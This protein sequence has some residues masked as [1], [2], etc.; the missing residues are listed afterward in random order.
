MK[1]N[2][3]KRILVPLAAGVLATLL[4]AGCTQPAT[5]TTTDADGNTVTI[6]WVDYPA[7]AG[8]PASDVL[9]LPM[10]EEVE[11]RAN[12]LISEVKDALEA[13]Y[14]ITEWTTS[15]E[16]GWF[17]EEG[18]GYGGTSLLTTYNSASHGA[19]I[20]IPVEQWDDV[21]DTVRTITQKYEISE[22][23]N[24][25]YIE[26]YPEWM[27]F[28]GFYRGTESFDIMV[29][30]DTLNPEHATSDS[31]DE[32]V[33]GVSLLYVITTISKGDRDEF[34][35]R[36]APYEGLRLPEATTSD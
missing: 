23:R 21:I 24:E 8:I 12:Q 6:D 4:L 30:D 34:I 36:A 25:T 22:E 20:R 26:E 31:D 5:T 32:L 10:A 33:T 27:R 11:A 2:A 18:N 15:N 19:E 3:R 14:G 29:Q 35:Q 13:E 7:N 9:A 1:H 28:G 16:G 17:P